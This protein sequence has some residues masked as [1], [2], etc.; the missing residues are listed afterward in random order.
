MQLSPKN[1]FP[2]VLVHGLLGWGED[3]LAGVDYWHG[4]DCQRGATGIIR[5]EVSAIASLHDRACELFYQLVGGRVDYGAEHAARYGHARFGRNYAVAKHPQWSAEQPLHFVGHSMGAPTIRML[6]QMLEE[7]AFPGFATD[8]RWVQSV[9]SISGVNNGSTAVY[10]FGVD[11]RSGLIKRRS[12]AAAIIKLAELYSALAPEKFKNFYDFDLAH[13]G[14]QRRP[15]ES[16]L[17][18]LRRILAHEDYLKDKNNPG[19]DLSV[20]GMRHWNAHLRTWADTYYFGF[21]TQ[22]TFKLPL[23]K[24]ILPKPNLNPLLLGVSAWMANKRFEPPLY[25]GFNSEA[26]WHNDGLVSTYSQQFPR[27]AGEH[28]AKAWADCQEL[29]PGYWHD[30]PLLD[31]WDHGDIIVAAPLRQLKGRRRFYAELFELLRALP[32]TMNE[33]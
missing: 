20:Q 7:Q 24:R 33:A 16:L 26:W 32:A 12:A 8:H 19:W 21:A 27:S 25:P 2:I 22:Q 6:Q 13:W 28:P 31:D 5:S 23:S 4:F 15:E 11:E 1:D 17:Q 18:H 29:K 9:S 30:M 10:L 14:L 3:E